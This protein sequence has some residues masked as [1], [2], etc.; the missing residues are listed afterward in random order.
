M[1][2]AG[3]LIRMPPPP[4][5]TRDDNSGAAIV[6]SP[7]APANGSAPPSLLDVEP[8]RS[9][10]GPVDFCI[11]MLEIPT[12][13]RRAEASSSM[14]PRGESTSRVV[15]KRRSTLNAEQSTIADRRDEPSQ[16]QPVTSDTSGIVDAAIPS[17][18]R[19]ASSRRS[20]S[21]N[22]IFVLAMISFLPIVSNTFSDNKRFSAQ[23]SHHAAHCQF[24]PPS[25][26]SLNAIAL[27]PLAERHP[28]IGVIITTTDSASTRSSR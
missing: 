19:S 2:A 1:S 15:D 3:L 26:R 17:A 16:V 8:S 25:S 12:Y 11:S 4:S 5:S 9:S 22:T 7:A 27:R 20:I 23:I 21:R 18:I 13:I 24:D 28:T 6:A 14:R 10:V